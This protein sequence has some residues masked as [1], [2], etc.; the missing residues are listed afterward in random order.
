M[1][2]DCKSLPLLS[3][4]AIGLWL[5]GGRAW[6]AALSLTWLPGTK[7]KA[8]ILEKCAWSVIGCG[9]V[10]PAA[11]KTRSVCHDMGAWKLH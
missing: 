11:E 2:C 4:L 5:T 7:G 6:A 9:A 1:G 10:S 3:P 8:L